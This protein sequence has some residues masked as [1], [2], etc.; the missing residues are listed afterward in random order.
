M[1]I[2]MGHGCRPIFGG[3]VFTSCLF[4]ACCAVLTGFLA[5]A[6]ESSSDQHSSYSLK[7]LGVGVLSGAAGIT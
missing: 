1:L 3:F 5:I 4:V 7:S 6:F 2:L